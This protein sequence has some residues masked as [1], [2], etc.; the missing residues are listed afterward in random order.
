LYNY[1]PWINDQESCEASAVGVWDVKEFY[2]NKDLNVKM[3]PS[4]YSCYSCLRHIFYVPRKL[5]REYDISLKNFNTAWITILLL[6][7]CGGVQA[8]GQ[9]FCLP[10]SEQS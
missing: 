7:A 9:I 4:T 1:R 5:Q 6:Q 10:L 3:W 8:G 2:L